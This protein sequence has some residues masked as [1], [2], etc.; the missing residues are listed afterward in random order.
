MGKKRA[1]KPS[2][3]APP[4]LPDGIDPRSELAHAER[5]IAVHGER[6]RYC[7]G[8]GW[9][10]WDA[11]RWAVDEAAVRELCGG[12]R[13]HVRI[14]SIVRRAGLRRM[15]SHSPRGSLGPSE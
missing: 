5:L 14:R 13:L 11:R 8:L 6:I 15:V 3:A 1:P 4:A 2:P 10:A 9:L 12:I 7:L